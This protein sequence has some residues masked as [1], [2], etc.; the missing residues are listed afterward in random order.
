MRQFIPSLATS[1]PR[2]YDQAGGDMKLIY[3]GNDLEG[4]VRKLPKGSSFLVMDMHRWKLAPEEDFL[5]VIDDPA[6]R[7][8]LEE[9]KTGQWVC[10]MTKETRAISSSEYPRLRFTRKLQVPPT[11]PNILHLLGP[12]EPIGKFVSYLLKE[13]DF[14]HSYEGEKW[15][16]EFLEE[17]IVRKSAFEGRLQKER[18]NLHFSF[19]KGDPEQVHIYFWDGKTESL[20]ELAGERQQLPSELFVIRTTLRASPLKEQSILLARDLGCLVIPGT[21]KKAWQEILSFVRRRE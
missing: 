16:E 14:V 9:L 6:H 8:K 18:A 21:M 19:E 11:L 3:D 12:M 7:E 5:Y 4:L 2:A 10:T 20:F 13:N 1:L 15:K 17:Q